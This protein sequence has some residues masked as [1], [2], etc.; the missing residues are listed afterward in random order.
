[1]YY[2]DPKNPFNV[3]NYTKLELGFYVKIWIDTVYLRFVS[4]KI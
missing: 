2:R 3:L 4:T 1:M